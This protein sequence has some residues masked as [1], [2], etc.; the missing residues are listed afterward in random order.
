MKKLVI[1][2]LPFFI[3]M[4]SLAHAASYTGQETIPTTMKRVVENGYFGVGGLNLS[5]NATRAEFATIAVRFKGVTEVQVREAAETGPYIDTIDYQGGWARYHI[6]MAYKKGLMFG[7]S[8]ERF[9]PSGHTTYIQLLAVMLRILGYEDGADF[10]QYPK[11]YY[12]KALDLGLA[13]PSM[14]MNTKVTR[15]MVGNTME[16]TLDLKLKGENKT[17]GEKLGISSQGPK[18]NETISIKNLTFT[19]TILGNFQGQLTGHS[20][21]KNYR[22]FLYPKS[23]DKAKAYGEAKVQENGTFEISGFSIGTLE[24]LLGYRYKVYDPQN[25]LVLQ[26]D[27]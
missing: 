2:I 4:G 23:D 7:V 26:G 5:K 24:K 1:V 6:G 19:T 11:D 9:H 21:F 20:S 13:N 16:K 12:Q 17:L 3:L 14:D 25:K 15:E 22:I 18:N 8:N 10:K 27:L